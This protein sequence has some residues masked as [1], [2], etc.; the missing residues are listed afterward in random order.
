MKSVYRFVKNQALLITL[1]KYQVFHT[2]GM[3]LNTR[4]AFDSHSN[5]VVC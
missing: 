3:A 5:F 4:G 2:Y 1:K